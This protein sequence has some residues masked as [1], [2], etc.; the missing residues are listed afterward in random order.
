METEARLAFE[1]EKKE[2]REEID[3]RQLQFFDEQRT[4]KNRI[5]D[6]EVDTKRIRCDIERVIEL[7]QKESQVCNDKLQ[8]M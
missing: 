5:I 7:Q 8:D 3:R 6:V 1:N 4:V 2:I